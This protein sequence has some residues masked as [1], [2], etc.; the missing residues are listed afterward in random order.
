MFQCTNSH[1][2]PYLMLSINS[3]IFGGTLPA[4]IQAIYHAENNN[5]IIT[6]IQEWLSSICCGNIQV[7][8]MG[9]WI[10]AD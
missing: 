6:C 4:T 9:K 1:D 3:E 8:E 7:E 2:K 5:I 10:P